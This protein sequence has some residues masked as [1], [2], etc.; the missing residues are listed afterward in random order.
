MAG[1]SLIKLVFTNQE[2]RNLLKLVAYENMSFYSRKVYKHF[3]TGYF[4]IDMKISAILITVH[5]FVLANRCDANQG[6]RHCVCVCVCVC[7]R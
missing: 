1:R 6:L 7:L 2:N 3:R 4:C 5:V